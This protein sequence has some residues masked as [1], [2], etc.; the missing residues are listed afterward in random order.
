MK[1]VHSVAEAKTARRKRLDF[2][3]K[4]A[5]RKRRGEN[6]KA[7]TAEAI[8]TSTAMSASEI[9]IALGNNFWHM[10]N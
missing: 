4:M 3:A 1:I 9:C 2:E 8:S 10:M 5:R 7:K 6:G